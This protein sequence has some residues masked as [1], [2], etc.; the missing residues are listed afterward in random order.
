MRNKLYK[1]YKLK[2]RYILIERKKERKK[3]VKWIKTKVH[4]ECNKFIPWEGIG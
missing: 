2:F 1:G 3:W 4:P